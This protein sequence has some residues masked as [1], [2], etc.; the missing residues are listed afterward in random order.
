MILILIYGLWHIDN[1]FTTKP[2]KIL[3]ATPWRYRIPAPLQVAAPRSRASECPH[4]WMGCWLW[5]GWKNHRKT[6]ES[7]WKM[8]I[9]HGIL[10]DLPSGVIKH[11][12]GKWTVDQWL[13][14]FYPL[15]TLFS[16]GIFQPAM[17]DETRRWKWKGMCKTFCE[18][19]WEHVGSHD[20]K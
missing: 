12:H 5:K 18:K 8:V 4:Q 10:W 17:L 3:W 11:G 20:K 15:F 7:H 9:Y 6:M 16:S 14:Y 1:Q 13:S 2:A 19:K